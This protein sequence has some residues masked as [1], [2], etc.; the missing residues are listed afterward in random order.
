M[1]QRS[2]RGV[3]KRFQVPVSS[4]AR[5]AH[6][7]DW[8]ARAAAIDAQVAEKA[9]RNLA[10]EIATRK[11]N[12]LKVIRLVYARFIERLQAKGS[13][14]MIGVQDF[15]AAAKHELFLLGEPTDRTDVNVSLDEWLAGKKGHRSAGVR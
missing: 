3:A 8:Q 1:P 9:H 10:E 11:T 15:L 13:A 5:W 2:L 7:F 6:K 12:Q 14:K 4:I